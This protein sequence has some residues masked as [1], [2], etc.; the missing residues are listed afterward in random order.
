VRDISLTGKIPLV[1]FDEFDCSFNQKPLGWLKYFLAP[2]Q[3]GTFVDCGNVHPIGK[4][5]FV[6]AGGIFSN[7][8]EFYWHV[9]L[10]GNCDEKSKDNLPEKG[11]DFVSRLRG[12]VN[13][14]GPNKIN[15]NENDLQDDTY[16]I[17]RAVHLRSLIKRNAPNII[18]KTTNKANIEKNLLITLLRIPKYKHGVRSM[19]AIIDM[20]M[21]QGHKSWGRA[22][23]PPKDQL[24]LHVDGNTFFTLLE[25]PDSIRYVKDKLQSR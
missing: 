14:L 19:E 25:N 13:I 24:E 11:L 12:Y 8:K 6:F 23:L 1:F 16:I 10:S 2:M 4:S 20:S 21:L 3:E 9:T 22:S 5:I 17:R 7:F 15:G 18:D